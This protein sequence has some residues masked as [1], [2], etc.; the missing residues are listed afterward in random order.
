MSASTRGQEGSKVES[1]QHLAD[2]Q[3]ASILIGANRLI[4]ERFDDGDVTA[5]PKGVE[6]D[7]GR[8]TPCFDLSGLAAIGHDHETHRHIA[9]PSIPQLS[10]I[11]PV[12]PRGLAARFL[13]QV[14]RS[15]GPIAA[16]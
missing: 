3:S 10:R 11:D 5:I 6:I 12:D 9:D 1:F 15:A 2:N 7:L 13:H 4:T 8:S 16:T 14:L